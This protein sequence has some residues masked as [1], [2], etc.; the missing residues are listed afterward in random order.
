MSNVKL[1]KIKN[2]IFGTLLALNAR[3]P[4]QK[5]QYAKA[6]V[7]VLLKSNKVKYVEREINFL[8]ELLK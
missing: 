7:T 5:C 6:K 1:E 8:F 3:N 4:S 2:E